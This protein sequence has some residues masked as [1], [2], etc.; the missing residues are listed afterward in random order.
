ME[1]GQLIEAIKIFVA[2]S[3]CALIENHERKQPGVFFVVP[4]KKKKKKK[5]KKTTT[6][7][8]K[9]KTTNICY[10]VYSTVVSRRFASNEYKK[11]VLFW[12]IG[13]N[14]VDDILIFFCTFPEIDIFFANCLLWKQLA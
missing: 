14:T 2:H 11:Y 4:N 10:A 9:K 5:K 7:K 1:A 12:M 13:E 6:T 3:Y 8:K